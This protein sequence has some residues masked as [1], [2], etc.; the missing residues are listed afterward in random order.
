[1]QKNV[2]VAT[3]QE[4]EDEDR[5][6]RELHKQKDSVQKKSDR[7]IQNQLVGNIDYGTICKVDDMEYFSINLLSGIITIELIESPIVNYMLFVSK[8]SLLKIPYPKTEEFGLPGIVSLKFGMRRGQPFICPKLVTSEVVES[9][10]L[11]LLNLSLEHSLGSLVLSTVETTIEDSPLL[12][13]LSMKVSVGDI[14]SISSQYGY[15][16][17]DGDSENTISGDIEKDRI[18]LGIRY[19]GNGSRVIDYSKPS[20][21]YV[22]DETI[23]GIVET[24]LADIYHVNVGGEPESLII[25]IRSELE[26][27][28]L[29]IKAEGKIIRIFLSDEEWRELERN[30]DIERLFINRLDQLFTQNLGYIVTN[31]PLH[32]SLLRVP[33]LQ[34]HRI[35]LIVAEQCV[36]TDELMRKYTEAAWGFVSIDDIDIY[37]N[38]S[39]DTIFDIG[40]E[41]YEYNLKKVQEQ[42]NGIFSDATKDNDGSEG[43]EHLLIKMFLVRYI[44]RNLIREN[45]LPST[46]TLEQ[47]K[48]NIKTEYNMEG[49]SP[50]ILNIIGRE[51]F[52]VETGHGV[53]NIRRK[54]TQK[55]IS[56]YEGIE[57]IDTIN[58]VIPNITFLRH[59]TELQQI[60]KTHEGWQIKEKKTIKF[61]T[62]KVNKLISL[63]D[64]S[65]IMKDIDK[66]IIKMQMLD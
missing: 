31:Y 37:P 57:Y 19:K 24:T 23:V 8:N 49:K 59:L 7:D 65:K 43:L 3:L 4:K 29:F 10:I 30:G 60:L 40:R 53:K 52:E 16:L 39:F 38:T 14:K 61:W 55:T 26:K 2:E 9:K 32:E 27:E 33:N 47:I 45:V 22:K 44:T 18:F 1:M 11:E 42:F 6:L 28:I 20:V 21:I 25:T 56:K 64:M 13:L 50:D 62:L 46:P 41:R 63:E 58:I 36:L 48:D 35:N 12:G 17:D 51:V 34:N 5:L 66:D 54:I 15:L